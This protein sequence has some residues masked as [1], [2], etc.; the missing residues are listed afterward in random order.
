MRVKLKWQRIVRLT[1]LRLTG[2]ILQT[3]ILML[4]GRLAGPAG[5][6]SLQRFLAWT[7]SIGELTAAGLSTHAMRQMV[8]AQKSPASAVQ[9]FTQAASRLSLIW[10]LIMVVAFFGYWQGYIESA[11]ELGM[12]AVAAFCFVLLCIVSRPRALRLSVKSI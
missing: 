5:V 6:G 11:L 1:G 8:S 12:T 9:Y 2:I 10:L 3:G 4:V 7:C